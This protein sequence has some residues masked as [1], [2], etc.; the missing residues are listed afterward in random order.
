MAAVSPETDAKHRAGGERPADAS[1]RTEF[2]EYSK[3]SNE[4]I[5]VVKPFPLHA[6][7]T[8]RMATPPIAW[9]VGV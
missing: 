7:R 6:E 9:A 2:P 3:H 5:S 4:E 1:D 8:R